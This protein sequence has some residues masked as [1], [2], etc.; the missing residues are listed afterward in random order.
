M[1]FIIDKGGC[2]PQR[3]RGSLSLV[4]LTDPS[5]EIYNFPMGF[6]VLIFKDTGFVSCIM[7]LKGDWDEHCLVG[8][9]S[10]KL[11]SCDPI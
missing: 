10:N 3:G 11:M 5:T 6:K 7:G 4:T 8:G 9:L 1:I 2:F